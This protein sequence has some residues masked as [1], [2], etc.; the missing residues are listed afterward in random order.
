[1]PQDMVDR[2]LW[3]GDQTVVE[4]EPGLGA[5]REETPL[6]PAASAA[7]PS[8]IPAVA[9]LQAVFRTLP[10]EDQADIRTLLARPNPPSP[11]EI[12]AALKRQGKI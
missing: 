11:E 4:N 7:Q 6:P 9:Q 10:E 12:L 8:T 1:M 3:V 2:T 5:E